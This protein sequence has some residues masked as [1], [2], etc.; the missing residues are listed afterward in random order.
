MPDALPIHIRSSFHNA[1]T[2][3]SSQGRK[4][5]DR[6]KGQHGTSHTAGIYRSGHGDSVSLTCSSTSVGLKQCHQTQGEGIRTCVEKARVSVVW[7]QTVLRG[8]HRVTDGSPPQGRMAAFVNHLYDNLARNLF[9]PAPYLRSFSGILPFPNSHAR[10]EHH[11][12]AG[13]QTQ[14]S[15]LNTILG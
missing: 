5:D 12:F 1:G 7:R 14:R 6:S 2:I 10:S 11:P 4:H 9:T 3:V 8:S 13:P 15:A